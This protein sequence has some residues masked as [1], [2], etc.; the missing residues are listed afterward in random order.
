MSWPETV[1]FL[2]L[3]ARVRLLDLRLHVIV[4]LGYGFGDDQLL[5]LMRRWLALHEAIG[6]LLP[7]MPE[8]EHVREVRAII[9]YVRS[10]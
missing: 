10:V 3:I 5:R 2:L 7:G 8:P 6:V 9:R 4:S 1:R